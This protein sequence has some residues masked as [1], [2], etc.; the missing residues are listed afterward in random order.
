MTHMT[1]L[2]IE[3]TPALREEMAECLRLEGWQVLEAAN[4]AE[5]VELASRFSPDVIVCDLQMPV[6]DGYGVHSSLSANPRTR[7]I[8]FFILTADTDIHTIQT[9]TRLPFE[10]ILTKPFDIFTLFECLAAAAA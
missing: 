5:G 6:L 9:R 3:D 8:P 1:V 2:L 10:R 7:D 4:G